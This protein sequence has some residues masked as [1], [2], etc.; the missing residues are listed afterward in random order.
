MPIL[1]HSADNPFVDGRQSDRA[2]AVRT[3]VERYFHELG[4]ATL[5]ELALAGGRRADLVAISA[6]G[7]I[8]II[9]VK[10]SIA[11]FRA[12]T[13]WPEYHDHCDFLYFATLTDVPRN[14]FPDETG[15][16]IADAFGADI[17]R[18]AEELRIAAARRK[19]VTLRFSRAAAQR[20]VRCCVHAGLDPTTLVE[21]DEG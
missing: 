21:T 5:P 17:L 9:E 14:I 3:G 15:L 10:S 18:P 8:A 13:K 1:S 11:D 2:L 6:K 7:D 19:A 4:W 12:D 16:M 20:L